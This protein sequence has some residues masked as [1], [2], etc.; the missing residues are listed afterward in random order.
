MVH[1]P[2]IITVIRAGEIK[3]AGHTVCMGKMRNSYK[4]LVA[5]PVCKGLFERCRHRCE[6]NITVNLKK[7]GCENAKWIQLAQHRVQW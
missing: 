7:I 3:W 2:N 1:S 4:I 5:N 6:N